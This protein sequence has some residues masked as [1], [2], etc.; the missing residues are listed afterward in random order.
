MLA[1]LQ[2][3]SDI[4][5][6]EPSCKV[7]TVNRSLLDEQIE[8]SWW[9]SQE[10]YLVP[11]YSQGPELFHLRC[12]GQA[13][14]E[15]EK[16]R[17]GW[18]SHP[19]RGYFLIGFSLI[20]SFLLI[21]LQGICRTWHR[22]FSKYMLKNNYYNNNS[23]KNNKYRLYCLV[24]VRDSSKCLTHY[25]LIWA[26]CYELDAYYHACVTGEETYWQRS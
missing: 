18:S 10:Q 26:R 6:F 2:L 20:P 9:L 3:W 23:N 19:A 25:G 15:C 5:P 11:W 7:G 13:Y 22:Y 1:S 17:S 16:W 21:I 24:G 14:A 12:S 8:V 4:I